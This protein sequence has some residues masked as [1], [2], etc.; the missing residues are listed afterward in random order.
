MNIEGAI[1]LF[2]EGRL[3]EASGSVERD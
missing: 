1:R 2:K 3:R